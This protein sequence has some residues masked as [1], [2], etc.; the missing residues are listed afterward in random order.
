MAQRA[1]VH[2]SPPHV[3]RSDYAG[4]KLASPYLVDP[5]NIKLYIHPRGG[6][7]GT[8]SMLAVRSFQSVYRL[9]QGV[10]DSLASVR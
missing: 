7:S 8:T 1:N 6:E 2:A 4:A 5:L 10:G 3:F 9:D